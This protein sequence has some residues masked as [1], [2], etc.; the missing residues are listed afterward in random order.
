M[1]SP[2]NATILGF[3]LDE[4]VDIAVAIGL[5]NRGANALTTADASLLGNSDED[6]LSFA[7]SQRYLLV[8]HDRDFLRRAAAGVRHAGIAYCAPGRRSVG[9]IVLRLLQLRRHETVESVED[10]VFYL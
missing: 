3:Y 8:T 7:R 1:S 9:E 6:Q 2:G 5:R 10:R 4:N